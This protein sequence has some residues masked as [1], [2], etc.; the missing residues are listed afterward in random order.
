[1]RVDILVI[2]GGII[3]ASILRKLAE[4]GHRAMLIEERRC[5][6]GA[7]GYSG[8]MVRTAHGQSAEIA[9]AGEGLAAYRAFAEESGGRVALRGSGHLYFGTRSVLEGL[10]PQ[11]AEVSEGA[12]LLQRDEIATRW[13]GLSVTAE[14]ALYEPQAGH[15]DPVAFV[16]HQLDMAAKSRAQVAEGTTLHHLLLGDAGITGAETSIGQIK[17][18]AVVL[19]TGP[20]TPALLEKHGLAVDRLWSQKIQVSGFEIGKQAHQWPGFIADDHGLN[21]VPAVSRGTYHIG[22]P[23]GQR[24]APEDS[25]SREATSDH[26]SA[27]RSAARALLAGDCPDAPFTGAMCH[28]DCYGT[29]PIGAIGP[30]RDLPSGLLLATGFSGGGFKMAPHA[31]R[32]ISEFLA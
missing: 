6:L 10:L 32:R 7:T 19:A 13:P 28:A 16:R 1:M 15:A 9:A 21:G 14:A 26:A 31:A 5:G 11:V 20:Q 4:A 3:G 23:T 2:G 8:A 29:T 18:R 12:C 17:A 24:I 27:T 30:A 22:L 25:T